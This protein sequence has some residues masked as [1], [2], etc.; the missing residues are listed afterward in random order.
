[1]HRS[2]QNFIVNVKQYIRSPDFF[3]SSFTQLLPMA[4]LQGCEEAAIRLGS[5]APIWV[6]LLD[7]ECLPE[8]FAV[9]LSLSLN[10]FSVLN[11]SH[12]TEFKE[13]RSLSSNCKGF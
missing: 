4:C 6:V 1:M 10:G 12:R 13:F 7:R 8:H 11:C 5:Q 9:S 2:R 3:S